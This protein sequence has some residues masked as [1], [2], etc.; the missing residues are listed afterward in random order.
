ML[1]EALRQSSQMRLARRVLAIPW[2]LYWALTYAFKRRFGL[3][4]SVSIDS[5]TR[6]RLLP[7]GQIARC[8]HGGSYEIVERRI[9]SRY[10]KRGM[11]VIDIGANVG[12]YSLIAERLVSPTGSVWAIEPSRDSYDRLLRNL[13]LNGAGRVTPVKV[14]LSSKDDHS[15]VLLRDRGHLDGERYL[16][17]DG[18]KV[19]DP[20][21]TECVSTISLDTFCK[22]RGIWTV[23]FI[24]MDVEGGEYEVIRGASKILAANPG[25]VMVFE[26]TR[27][28]CVRAGSTPQAIA[29][30][31]AEHGFHLYAWDREKK[32]W[33]SN[34]DYVLSQS[35]AWAAASSTKLPSP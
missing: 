29:E 33:D 18:G 5:R 32:I 7:E 19:E 28:G 21:D 20:A 26:H 13:E 6:V 3:P 1:I 16:L 25:L 11:T 24:K 2:R 12:L 17:P 34:H 31:L 14:A 35:N 30:L 22:R 15:A 10:L 23:D 8:L 4:V 27:E 9:V